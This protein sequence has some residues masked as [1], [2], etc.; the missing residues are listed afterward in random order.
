MVQK[1]N[2]AWPKQEV[3]QSVRQLEGRLVSLES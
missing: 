2:L 1:S 3:M